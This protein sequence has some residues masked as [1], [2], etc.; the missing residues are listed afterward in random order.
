M[1]NDSVTKDIPDVG[2]DKYNLST[3]YLASTG[4]NTCVIFIVLFNNS[5]KIFMEHRNSFPDDTKKENMKRCLS[6]VAS[7]IDSLVQPNT[8]IS[9]VVFDNSFLKRICS[10]NIKYLIRGM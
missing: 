1:A 3:G 6:Y 7:H 10:Y 5:R 8:T 9:L 4:A 2:I